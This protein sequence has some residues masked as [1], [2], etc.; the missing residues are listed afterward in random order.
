[1]ATLQQSLAVTRSKLDSLVLKAPVAGKLTEDDLQVGQILKPGDRLG[2]VVPATGFK[3]LADIDEYYLGRVAIG[4]TADVTLDGQS[5]PMVVTRVESAGEGRDLPGGARVQ[6]PAAGRPAAG[7]GAGGQAGGGRRP[8]A[9]WC[10][11][12]ARSWS[13]PAA[14]G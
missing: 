11:R 5:Y 9:R 2:E 3:A 10:C 12:P 8:A 1:M 13:A 7:R 6:G 14:T 4:Q